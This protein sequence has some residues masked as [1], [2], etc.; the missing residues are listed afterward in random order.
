MPFPVYSIDDRRRVP[1]IG[2]LFENLG[3]IGFD[4]G[5]ELRDACPG[6]VL[7]GQN[8]TKTLIANNNEPRALAFAA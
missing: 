2:R 8:S 5:V 4:G 1:S 6:V 7:A 3:P